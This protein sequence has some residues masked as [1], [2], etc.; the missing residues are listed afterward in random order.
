MKCPLCQQRVR[1][2][3]N[4]YHVHGDPRCVMSGQRAPITGT[5][6]RDYERRAHTVLDLAW[7]VQDEDPTVV[8]TVLGVTEPD[9]LRRLLMVALA[10][11]PVDRTPA[12][13]FAWVHQLPVATEKVS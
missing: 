12:E 8:W 3:D 11:I 7:Q 10:G 6:N 1:T 4:R 9:E 13:V 5:S 2:K